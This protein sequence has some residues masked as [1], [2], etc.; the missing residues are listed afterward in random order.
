MRLTVSSL[1]LLAAR[2]SM[3]GIAGSRNRQSM[4]AELTR[5]G[6][7]NS[8][9]TRLILHKLEPEA[10]TAVHFLVPSESGDAEQ[11]EFGVINEGGQ[12]RTLK[13]SHHHQWQVHEKHNSE[14]SLPSGL[15][16]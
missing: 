13:V 8:E 2:G 15:T 9:G 6:T 4:M 14:C 11:V 12:G 10:D 3:T 1:E 16:Q 5:Q 7:A